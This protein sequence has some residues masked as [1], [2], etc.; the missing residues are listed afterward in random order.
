[1]VEV[2]AASRRST[3]GL[4]TVCCG[5]K[6]DGSDSSGRAGQ[7]SVGGASGRASEEAVMRPACWCGASERMHM[8]LWLCPSLSISDR[9]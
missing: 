3:P 7:L 6:A 4:G 9:R 5:R 1:M 8:S 2:I